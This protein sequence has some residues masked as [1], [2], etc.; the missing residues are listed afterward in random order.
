[1][2]VMAAKHKQEV[3]MALVAGVGLEV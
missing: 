3:H 2:A 1:M